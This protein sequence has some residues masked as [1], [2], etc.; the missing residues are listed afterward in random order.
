MLEDHN[1]IYDNELAKIGDEI[2]SDGKTLLVKELF[3]QGKDA[4]NSGYKHF[5]V[6][7]KGVLGCEEV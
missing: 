3:V 7:R 6:C 4:K 5:V 2:I 1:I